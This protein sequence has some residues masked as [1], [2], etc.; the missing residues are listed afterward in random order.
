[1]LIINF[2]IYGKLLEIF[3]KPRT[4][5]L[6]HRGRVLDKLTLV[7]S[8][9]HPLLL[10]IKRFSGQHDFQGLSPIS[11]YTT[12]NSGEF[13]MRN[14]PSRVIAILKDLFLLLIQRSLVLEVI[15]L[16]VSSF[17]MQLSHTVNLV[18]DIFEER[19]KVFL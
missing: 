6:K 5:F 7:V 18:T 1:L 14:L 11:E 17:F 4:S 10:H 9:S 2:A 15:L 8:E 13:V 16:N 3:T 19:I 12:R